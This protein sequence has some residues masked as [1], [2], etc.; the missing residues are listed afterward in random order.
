MIENQVKY[1]SVCDK[2]TRR[3]GLNNDVYCNTPSMAKELGISD[4]WVYINL[5]ECYCPDCVSEMLRENM[6]KNKKPSMD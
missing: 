6:E 2:C 1:I 5:N 4:G 3:Y